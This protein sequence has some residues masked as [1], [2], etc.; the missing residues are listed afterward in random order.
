MR[1]AIDLG[2]NLGLTVVAEGVEGTEH[3]AALRELGCDIAQG[4]HYARPMLGE[5]LGELLDRVG[6]IHDV[7]AV[8]PVS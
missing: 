4:Y 2:H 5:A 1:T 8:R 6:S 3:V 7:V